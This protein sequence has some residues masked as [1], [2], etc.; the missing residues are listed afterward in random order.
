MKLNII[1]SKSNENVILEIDKQLEEGDHIY[2]LEFPRSPG[3]ILDRKIQGIKN[4][5]ILVINP[6]A[7][8]IQP[9]FIS[10]VKKS[11]ADNRI[12]VRLPAEP[13]SEFV[14]SSNKKVH[15]NDSFCFSKTLYR[16]FLSDIPPQADWQRCIME[17]SNRMCK[18]SVY[19]PSHRVDG[20]SDEAKKA[21]NEF[22]E[23]NQEIFIKEEANRVKK[24][25]LEF[26]SEKKRLDA[27]EK[28]I[29]SEDRVVRRPRTKTKRVSL[30]R[31]MDKIYAHTATQ[32]LPQKKVK[33][34]KVEVP[35]TLTEVIE[36]KWD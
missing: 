35:T 29:R 5:A 22:I 31:N 10:S 27:I 4:G 28:F 11:M 34:E 15:K 20:T 24:E 13:C 18:G 33:A 17:L 21:M 14:L 19:V 8:Y 1:V 16:R 9:D 6:E 25:R 7:T 30:I 23:A 12:L 26:E 2:L 32:N 36:L 3:R